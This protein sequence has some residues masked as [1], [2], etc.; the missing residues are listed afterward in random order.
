MPALVVLAVPGVVWL[1]GAARRRQRGTWLAALWVGTWAGAAGAITIGY[2]AH[3]YLAD[4]VPIVLLPA[5]V[6]AHVAL[7]RAGTS[8]PA[9]RRGG[10]V[11]VGLLVAA[12]AWT[13]LGLG[14]VAQHERGQVVPEEWRAELARW[15]ADLPGGR[16]PVVAVP[17]DADELPDA[18]DGTLGVV[19]DCLGLYARVGDTWFG[20]DRGPGVGVHDLRVDLD[21]LETG[22]RVPLVAFGHG[23]DA[24]V[25]A[26]VRLPDGDVRLDVENPLSDGWSEGF[27]VSLDGEV[28]VRV[29]T[30]PR[31]IDRFVRV[32]RTVLY[33]QWI[34][35]LGTEPILGALPA[36]T[37]M[38]G[39]ADSYPGEVEPLPFDA[40]LCVDA[41][42]RG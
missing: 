4:L 33:D 20:V 12:G 34:T 6:G 28:T 40:T 42:G 1:V 17:A 11:A 15:R 9:V 3:R 39:V 29:N 36:G 8:R 35:D 10:L 19:G 7:G 30:D 32:G 23:A 5:L 14:I 24:S 38:P 37:S 2:V 41:T 18:P 22:E 31:A 13:N 16:R 21:A 25:A 26:L 27:P